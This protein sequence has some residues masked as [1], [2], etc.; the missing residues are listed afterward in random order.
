MPARSA[1]AC[2][3]LPKFARLVSSGYT[4]AAASGGLLKKRSSCSTGRSAHG[5]LPG[6]AEMQVRA[7]GGGL[8][9]LLRRGGHLAVLRSLLGLQWK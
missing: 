4:I 2:L 9:L 1:S 6:E 3:P 5:E 8:V 7:N